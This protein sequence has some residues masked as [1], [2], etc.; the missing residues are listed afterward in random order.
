MRTS[1]PTASRLQPACIIHCRVSSA[2]QAE[3]GESL[4]VQAAICRKIAG[5]KGWTLAREPWEEAFS[6][7]KARPVFKTILNYLEKHPGQVQ[8]YLF[9]SIDRFTRGGSLAYEQMKRELALRGVEMVDTFGIIQPVKNTLEDVGFEYEWS[10]SSP[11][12]VAEVMAAVAAKHEVTTILTRLIGQEIRLTQ[13]GYK[14][15]SPQDGYINAKIHVEN[16]R[17]TIQVPDPDR[18]RYLVTMFEMRASGQLT[19]PEIC[20]RIN[21]MGYRTRP[22]KRWD[23]D[24]RE[25]VGSGGGKP[26]TPKRL[27]EVVQRPIYCGVV[28][29]K[30]TRWQPVRTPYP[31]LIPIDLFNAANRGKV[32][33]REAS[34][35][36]LSILYDH[37]PERL[38]RKLNRNNPLFPYR[39]VVLCPACRKP[40]FGSSPRGRSGAQYPTYHCARGHRYFGIR[41]D[42]LDATTE[43]FVEKLRLLP[44]THALIQANTLDAF[45]DREN[46]RVKAERTVERSVAELE[47]RKSEAMRAFKLATTDLLR[48]NFEAEAADLQ[49]QIGKAL[50]APIEAEIEERDVEQYLLDAKMIVEHPSILL[51]SP[52]SA[53][54]QQALYSLVFEQ[55]PT[56]QEMQDGTAKLRWFYWLYSNVG[57]TK[58]V[59]VRLRE[60]HWNQIEEAILHWKKVLLAFPALAAKLRGEANC[61]S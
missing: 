30:W 17:R 35:K 37:H 3:E 31:G 36:S 33:I 50:G 24:H 40:L 38:T 57:D 56:Y 15:R 20:E 49:Q 2:K 16:R 27:Q 46:E 29:E 61:T 53:Q 11:S 9:R 18:A 41:K 8:Y 4:E 6:G 55:L 21:A 14:I 43:Q 1:Q 25:V 42:V 59:L 48:Q 47:T 39:H 34:D 44:D 45:R 10:K 52:T 23:A 22:H 58:S 51:E 5:E 7:R 26:L 32:F 28:C 12:E 60:I 13:R 54:E 19:D